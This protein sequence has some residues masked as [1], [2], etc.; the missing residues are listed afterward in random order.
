MVPCLRSDDL[1]DEGRTRAN[2]DDLEVTAAALVE[3]RDEC[4]EVL[5]R[6]V[7]VANRIDD[8]RHTVIGVQDGLDIQFGQQCLGAGLIQFFV[9]IDVESRGEVVRPALRIG[10]S[11]IHHLGGSPLGQDNVLRVRIRD[12]TPAR[13]G[14][15]LADLAAARL[16]CGQSHGKDDGHGKECDTFHM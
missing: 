10:G 7:F 8:D 6:I 16:R 1:V 11:A 13:T 4:I 14:D 2:A 12:P 9:R 15:V 5:G 3:L